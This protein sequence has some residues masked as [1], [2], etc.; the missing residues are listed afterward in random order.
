MR[1]ILVSILLVLSTASVAAETSKHDPIIATVGDTVIT[2]SQVDLKGGNRTIELAQELFKVRSQY[3]YIMLSDA[4]LDKEAAEK[5]LTTNKLIDQEISNKVLLVTQQDINAYIASNPQVKD[6]NGYQSKVGIYLKVE[7]H[8]KAKRDYVNTLFKKHKVRLAMYRPPELP[9]IKVAGNHEV[10]SGKNGAPIEIVLFS[11][12]QCP[13]CKQLHGPL[14]QLGRNHPN[15]VLITHKHFPIPGHALGER[16]AVGSYCASKQGK[17]KEYYDSVFTTE[18][19]LDSGRLDF[20]PIQI[21]L[22]AV[23]FKSCIEDPATQIA[24]DEDKNEGKRIGIRATPTMVI[25][26][27][28]YPGAMSYERLQGIVTGLQAK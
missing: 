22:D 8:K 24:V 5:G 18:G 17:F 21:G 9:P 2:Q 3:L 6:V 11:D 10:I 12:F 26:G 27:K 15:D 19:R 4:I 25:N 7:R 14:S 1:N 23:V 13:Y 20:I 16:A 28:I